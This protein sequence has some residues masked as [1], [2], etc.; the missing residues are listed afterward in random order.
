MT[1]SNV[2]FLGVSLI[3]SAC[4]MTDCYLIECS[5]FVGL[6]CLFD[7]C[8]EKRKDFVLHHILVLGMIH[9]LN[10]HSDIENLTAMISVILSTEI[11]TIFLAL[12]NL[13]EDSIVKNVNKMAFLSTFFYYRVYNYSYLLLDKDMNHSFLIH[14]R[15]NF[16][17]CQ[18]YTGIYGLFLLNLYW[19]SLI[20]KKCIKPVNEKDKNN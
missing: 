1:F 11:S 18:V 8:V 10:Q 2:I 14:S 19:S 5:N 16:E 13:L 12:N 9:Y 6:K 4:V 17:Y 15:N 3:S 7:L 20:L